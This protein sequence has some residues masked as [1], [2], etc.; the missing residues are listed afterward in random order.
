VRIHDNL[1]YRTGGSGVYFGTWNANGP[2]R[3]IWL[4]NNT[5]VDCGTDGHWTG[6]TGGIDVR[7]PN[8]EGVVI[9]NNIVVGGR[10]WDIATFAEP[11]QWPEVFERQGIVIARN[12]TM[13]FRAISSEGGLYNRIYAT[14]SAGALEVTGTAGVGFRDV[15]AADYRLTERSPARSAADASLVPFDSGPDLGA[16]IDS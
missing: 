3:S 15:D 11:R 13:R 8:V 7:S 12:L 9:A 6:A 2:R 4:Y 16:R 10:H 1:V 14:P 5:V